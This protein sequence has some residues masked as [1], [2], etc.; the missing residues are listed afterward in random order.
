MTSEQAKQLGDAAVTQLVEA[1]EAGQIDTLKT[2]LD[3]QGHL[4]GSECSASERLATPQP[5][6]RSGYRSQPTKHWTGSRFALRLELKPNRS[7]KFQQFPAP[8]R[9]GS[10]EA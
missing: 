2:H 7:R 3:L 9:V 1:I 8:D 6:I 5:L 10:K 4:P